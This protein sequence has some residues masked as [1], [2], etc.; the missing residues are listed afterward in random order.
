MNRSKNAKTPSIKSTKS[1]SSTSTRYSKSSL[2]SGASYSGYPSEI[3]SGSSDNRRA[4]QQRRVTATFGGGVGPSSGDVPHYSEPNSRPSSLREQASKASILTGSSE[5]SVYTVAS[6]TN[7]GT[8]L[9]HSVQGAKDAAANRAREQSQE[10]RRLED[11]QRQRERDASRERVQR[12]V[13][14]AQQITVK[15]DSDKERFL[16]DAGRI[17]RERA[18]DRGKRMRPE[19]RQR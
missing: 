2:A 10:R 3:P 19:D 18:K 6:E 13:E 9:K 16:R 5:N 17:S 11:A 4:Q 14:D 12:L 1:S 15:G 8:V 7:G